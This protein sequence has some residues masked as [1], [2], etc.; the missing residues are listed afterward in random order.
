MG[1]KKRKS[2]AKA[3]RKAKIKRNVKMRGFLILFMGCFV[4]LSFQIFRIQADYGDEFERRVVVQHAIHNGV[5]RFINPNRGTILDRNH[6]IRPLAI[7]NTVYNV[8]LDVRLL[9]NSTEATQQA[10][11]EKLNRILGIPSEELWHAIAINPETNAPNIDRHY[12]VIYNMLDTRTKTL[13]EEENPRHVWFEE[14]TKRI[15]PN[16]SLGAPVIG[17]LRGDNSSWGLE[18]VFN[19]EL[20]GERGRIVRMYN[21][22]N[23]VVTEH[24]RPIQGGTVITTLDLAI[25]QEAERI[26]TRWGEEA[27]AQNAGIIVANPRTMEIIAMAQYPSFDLNDPFNIEAITSTAL[28]EEMRELSAEEQLERWFGIWRN[29]NITHTLEQGSVYKPLVV[30]A[31]LEAG[32]INVHDTF[33]CGGSRTV[34]GTTI[35][36][37]SIAT[38]GCG[39]LDVEGVLARSCNVGMMIIMERMGRDT[40]YDF[41]RA[42][43]I[44]EITGIDL[45]GEASAAGLVY[46]RS[47]LGPVE[48][49]TTSIGQG[50]NVTPLQI[51]AYF[52]SIINGGNFMEPFIVSQIVDENN[53]VIFEHQPQ[54]LRRPISR[55]VSDWVRIAMV[56]AVEVT[57]TGTARGVAVDGFSIGGKTGT[58]QTGADRDGIT[59]T[60]AGYFPA[61]DPE[62]III[63]VIAE[64]EN[65]I[66]GSSQTIPMTREMI[67]SIIS[68]R[69]MSPTQDTTGMVNNTNSDLII[70]NDYIGRNIAEVSGE[71]NRLGLDYEL[72]SPGNIVRS[73]RPAAGS[74]VRLGTRIFFMLEDNGEEE[75]TFIPNVIGMTRSQA[76]ETLRNADLIPAFEYRNVNVNNLDSED[77]EEQEFIVVSQP[78][79]FEIR[80]APRTQIRLILE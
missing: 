68:I 45:L 53:N 46:N 40:Y 75:L 77:E 8:I 39:N 80:V 1:E 71:L 37:W 27:R 16:G 79:G 25:Q 3:E 26:V 44:G 73:Q 33:F 13:L 29:F 38:G 69:R 52:S 78:T 18:A 51:A 48:M 30:A 22:E 19:R 12:H 50:F 15:Y 32:V 36:C 63:S 21:G 65:Y 14:D 31:A 17:F 56:A 23:N 58:A 41:Q 62:Y 76:E 57:G 47:T 11:I 20:T 55:E 74:Q 2:R 7:S 34:A 64:P 70:V 9:A 66:F 24:I 72:N 60:F 59:L 42:F 10:T 6:D 4:F 35:G 49:A 61:E 54:V 67:E 5:D 43:G 28:R